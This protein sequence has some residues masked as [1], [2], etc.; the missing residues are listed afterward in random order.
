MKG[1]LTLTAI[2]V[3]MWKPIIADASFKNY[4]YMCMYGI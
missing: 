2:T 4:M 3:V 1:Q